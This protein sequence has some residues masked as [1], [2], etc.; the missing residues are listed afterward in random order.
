M[1]AIWATDS[2]S[3]SL[4]SDFYKCNHFHTLILRIRW[5]CLELTGWKRLRVKTNVLLFAKMIVFQESNLPLF[6]ATRVR[7][8]ACV[9]AAQNTANKSTLFI[10]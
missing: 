1:K 5:S 9:C 10:H 4:I 2:L 3:K 8:C 7:A 6:Q